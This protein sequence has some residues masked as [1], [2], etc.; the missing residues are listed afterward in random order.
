L[1]HG[2][3]GIHA[4]RVEKNT[5]TPIKHEI[6]ETSEKSGEP[7]SSPKC[8]KEVAID[9][10]AAKT[11]FEVLAEVSQGDRKERHPFVLNARRERFIIA[12]GAHMTQG[13]DFCQ[14]R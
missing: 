1:T 6:E 10:T 13:P 3:D 12:A 2:I 7:A 11:F 8:G 9:A 14:D 5:S 4:R